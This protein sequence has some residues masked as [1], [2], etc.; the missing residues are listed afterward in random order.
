MK[1]YLKP[2]MT[3]ALVIGLTCLFGCKSTKISKNT[4]YG[5]LTDNNVYLQATKNNVLYQ[6]TEK[7]LYDA[8]KLSRTSSGFTS[9]SF[10]NEMIL[11]IALKDEIQNVKDIYEGKIN[12]STYYDLEEN[13][14]EQEYLKDLFKKN[15]NYACYTLTS[16]EKI[17]SLADF[18]KESL[19]QKYID[20][21]FNEGIVLSFNKNEETIVEAA[22][23]S[24]L[25]TEFFIERAKYNIAE[26][27]L[28]EDI[29]D[30]DNTNYF[31]E[32]E[33]YETYFD[34]N[35][36]NST[37]NKLILIKFS[38]LDEYKKATE[39]LYG[40]SNLET[41]ENFVKLYNN[42]YG[43]YRT[44][45]KYQ[46]QNSLE[47]AISYLLNNNEEILTYSKTE[48]S[49]LNSNV[50]SY[51]T[52]ELSCKD[53]KYFNENSLS[54][55]SN[56]YVIFK[57]EDTL[58]KTYEEK[59][60]EYPDLNTL[61]LQKYR[62]S[63]LTTTYINEKVNEYLKDNA[64]ITIYDPYLELAYSTLNT[65]FN[66]S[67]ATST[68]NICKVNDKTISV[69]E[70]Y[71][72]LENAY[73]ATT[74]YDVLA[75]KILKDSKYFN[76]VTETEKKQYKSDLETIISNYK[77]GNYASIG[78][79]STTTEKDFYKF[80]FNQ[81]SKQEILDN[82]YQT[83]RALELL[84]KDYELLDNVYEKFENVTKDLYNNTFSINC[85]HFLIYIDYEDSDS[86]YDPEKFLETLDE[87]S[88]E[89]FKEAIVELM[90]KVYNNLTSNGESEV[91]SSYDSTLDYIINSY[92]SSNRYS[93][94][95]WSK[96]HKLGLKLKK[97][98]LG[99][100]TNTSVLSYDSKFAS[101]VVE[102]ANMNLDLEAETL[103][104]Y[105][106]YVDSEK[107]NVTSYDDLLISSF[108]FHLIFVTEQTLN[109][110]ANYTESMDS[111]KT[112]SEITYEGRQDSLNAYSNNDY[113][114]ANQIEIY[115]REKDYSTGIENLPATKTNDDGKKINV[116]STIETFFG[117]IYEKYT[118]DEN[119]L[120]I[121]N[122][123]IDNF[124]YT[125]ANSLETFNKTIEIA[126]RQ[127]QDYSYVGID[128]I[129]NPY[130]NW[131]QT[132]FN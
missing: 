78:I 44:T 52:D 128:Y 69:L 108:G 58:T 71:N 32:S 40:N 59:L 72:K 111:K 83:N 33:D 102:L 67:K 38:S 5:N 105:N 13:Q 94:D 119:Q 12:G 31:D 34:S 95:E 98:S 2:L 63:K 41:L 45:I 90:T 91:V 11:E 43:E 118:S 24:S 49:A 64:D 57:L 132:L 60:A 113:P 127:F 4:P 109:T 117:E 70:F 122:C 27:S 28:T 54:Y 25:L 10:L 18:Q 101:R 48:F 93:N 124:E 68:E 103:G 35:L 39:N 74:A 114:S 112:Y 126:K 1:R 84:L 42:F 20:S 61:I 6:V 123:Y 125:N 21:L 89:K 29:K 97:E 121:L 86:T 104:K 15:I 110:S 9:L 87:A 3:L 75:N 96:F 99:E 107:G 51:I 92:N 50:Q 73:G 62:I 116:K 36:K 17:N 131:F 47:D 77:N 79:P 30:E 7:E 129:N 115:L 65:F 46:S 16:E 85:F 53:N 66:R 81:N 120:F 8:L 26:R 82:Y 19:E 56:Y 55:S 37:E 76:E 130:S 100:I 80:Y 14:T 23:K 88:Q 106:A 22:E